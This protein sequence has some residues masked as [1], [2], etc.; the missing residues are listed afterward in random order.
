MQFVK[1]ANCVFR[2]FSIF[3]GTYVEENHIQISLL[4]TECAN[5]LLKCLAHAKNYD[6][7]AYVGMKFAESNDGKDFGVKHNYSDR[8]DIITKQ[9]QG[10]ITSWTKIQEMYELLCKQIITK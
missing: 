4:F 8:Y 10:L 1:K 2:L 7:R 3:D 6:K 9:T 5:I